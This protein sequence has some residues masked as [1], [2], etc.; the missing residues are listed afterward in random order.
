MTTT[1]PNG[2][3]ETI[4]GIRC[5]MQQWDGRDHALELP[6]EREDGM[7]WYHTNKAGDDM[8]LS[9]PT[10]RGFLAVFLICGSFYILKVDYSRVWWRRRKSWVEIVN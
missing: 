4:V 9:T 1:A 5:A 10:Y 2:C 8:L 6:P 7:V 3:V